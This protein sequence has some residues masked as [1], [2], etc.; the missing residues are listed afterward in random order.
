MAGTPR[1]PPVPGD[2][3]AIDQEIVIPFLRPLQK[4]QATAKVVGVDPLLNE[5]L[6]TE[7]DNP[8]VIEETVSQSP[9]SSCGQVQ[10]LDNLSSK[11]DLPL[12]NAE[13][14]RRTYSTCPIC[15]ESAVDMALYCGHTFC[16]PCF[17]LYL[18]KSAEMTIYP[19]FSVK[20]PT[21]REKAKGRY[22]FPQTKGWVAMSCLDYKGRSC[23]HNCYV[24]GVR[25]FIA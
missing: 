5:M 25:L 9:P 2:A 13:A 22:L 10:E 24:E 1:K 19:N 20:C 18:I 7:S 21:C 4:R 17:S 11:E 8:I 16:R 23:L 15:Q 3:G 12:E 6:L 14:S